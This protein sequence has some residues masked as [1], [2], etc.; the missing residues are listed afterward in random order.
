MFIENENIALNG[1]SLNGFFGSFWNGF[2]KAIGLRYDGAQT[3]GF[4][5]WLGRSI[6]RLTGIS[7]IT[8]LIDD[9]SAEAKE[10]EYIPTS[11]EVA[12][13]QPI[14]IALNNWAYNLSDKVNLV[15]K[16]TSSSTE[17]KISILN[18]AVREMNIVLD[19]YYTEPDSN[20]SSKSYDYLIANIEQLVE[21]FE[22][23][24]EDLLKTNGIE[25]TKFSTSL[26]KKSTDVYPIPQIATANF[27][28][29]GNQYKLNSVGVIDDSLILSD[30]GINPN[31]N[32]LD[33]A[34]NTANTIKGNNNYKTVIVLFSLAFLLALVSEKKSKN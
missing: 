24:I 7:T 15:F 18:D 21:T 28:S 12:V 20:I 27:S 11:N 23:T 22:L 32:N 34:S 14:Q 30:G 16:N 1:T 31:L 3:D 5:G 2:K 26:S 6:G 29:F 10:S 25:Y 8:N 9:L 13:L 19:Y 33:N 17:S 4:W